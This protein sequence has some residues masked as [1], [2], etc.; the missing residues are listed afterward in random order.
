MSDTINTRRERAI[1]EAHYSHHELLG[2][3]GIGSQLLL[4]QLFLRRV[5]VLLRALEDRGQLGL[6]L[7]GHLFALL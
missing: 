2:D 3:S 6:D 4:L 7:L 5:R 1:I